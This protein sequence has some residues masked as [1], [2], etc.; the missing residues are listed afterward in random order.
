MTLTNDTQ[1]RSGENI[2][3]FIAMLMALVPKNLVSWLTGRFMELRLPQPLAT[4]ACQIF[5]AVFGID[6]SEAEKPITAYE[7]LEALFTRRLKPGA[8]PIRG[9]VCSP[10]DGYLACSAPVID[11]MAIQAKGLAY[12]VGALVFG[13][14]AP[15]AT[16]FAWYH[17]VYLA[18]HNYHRVHAPTSGLLTAV[19][20]I[21]GELWPVNR[22]FVARVPRLFARNERL[23]FDF[24]LPGGGCMHLVMVGA[25]NVGRIT[26][27]MA[28]EVVTNDLHRQLGGLGEQQKRLDPPRPVVAG[29]ELGTFMLGS[30]VIL[31]WDQAALKSTAFSA[32]QVGEKQPILMGQALTPK[33]GP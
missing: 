23:V 11:G 5:A 20:Y 3:N 12:T 6:M 28:P 24:S 22:P 13:K 26:T 2:M 31:I 9:P 1:A 7:S 19:R 8:R 16:T 25:L 14:Q 17:T 10:A 4:Y 21:P 32:V 30:T 18:P 33:E 15:D 29:E 27:P